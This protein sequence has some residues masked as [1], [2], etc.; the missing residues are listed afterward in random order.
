MPKH[1]V[2][3][4]KGNWAAPR[5]NFADPELIRHQDALDVDE[6]VLIGTHNEGK[7]K[8]VAAAAAI[9]VSLLAIL[10]A[11][12][13]ALASSGAPGVVLNGA[14][15][16]TGANGQSGNAANRAQP[17]AN[18]EGDEPEIP[19]GARGAD[20]AQKSVAIE[21]MRGKISW[22]NFEG[23]PD[24]PA[25]VTFSFAP[26]ATPAPL[27]DDT[28]AA[29]DASIRDIV[30]DEDTTCGFVFVNM[31]TGQG[32]AFN[33]HERLYSA[34]A[35][36]APYVLF[37]LQANP[38]GLPD[39]E[40]ENIEAL[41]VDSDNDAF[42][43]LHAAHDDQGYAEWLEAQGVDYDNDYYYY[44]PNVS[45]KQLAGMWADMYNYIAPENETSAWLRDLLANT[46]MSFIRD[47]LADTG[48]QVWNKAGWI[49][50]YEVGDAINDAAIIHDGPTAYVMA[51]VSTE[52]DTDEGHTSVA[53]L[54]RTLWQSRWI[55]D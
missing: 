3:K 2:A 9:V 10:I 51:I 47:G 44:Y 32:I 15:S 14:L 29:L 49:S 54:A 26:G 31:D 7:R 28:I 55:L 38:E 6:D 4:K 37:V 22:E 24:G 50:D 18:V 25:P 40:R 8:P 36:K 17:S 23:V 1:S 42:D 20:A 35:I 11:S 45:A 5:G 41:I 21:S 19:E 16:D 34:S 30:L 48:A 27:N 33:A 52:Q 46:N 43:V 39:Y 12:I 53:N 13:G